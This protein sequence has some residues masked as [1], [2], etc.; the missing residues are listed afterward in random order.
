MQTSWNIGCYVN[1]RLFQGERK[2]LITLMLVE[3]IVW[4]ALSKCFPAKGL[5][6]GISDASTT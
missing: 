2:T 3:Y 6:N 1:E 5:K 4:L